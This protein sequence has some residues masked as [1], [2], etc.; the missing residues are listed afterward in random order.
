MKKLILFCLV[1]LIFGSV[2]AHAKSLQARFAYSTFFAPGSGPYAETYLYVGGHSVQYALNPNNKFQASIEVSLIFSQGSAVK[3]FDKYNLLSP[4]LADTLSNIFNFV[5]QQRI[6]LPNGTYSMEMVIR[7]K[8]NANGKPY[9]ITQEVT[10]SYFPNV[11]AI[12]DIEILSSFKPSNEEKKI[13]KNGYELV[14]LVDN[15]FAQEDNNLKFY[16]EIY[17]TSAVLSNEGYLLSYHIE[18]YEQKRI[19]NDFSQQM[20][21]PVKP[22]SIVLADMNITELPSGNYN[23]VIEVRNKTNELLAMREI[24]FQRSKAAVVTE[25]GNVDIRTLDV[26]N[27][28]A[29]TYTSKDTLA[30]Y[31]RCLWPISSPT[32]NIWAMNQLEQSDVKLMQQF[33]YDFWN[34]RNAENPLAAWMTYKAEVDKVNE[35][36]SN[37]N[38]KGYMTERGRVYLQYGPPNQLSK[39]YNEPATYP[40]EVWQY[41]KV[42]NQSNRKFVFYANELASNDMVLLHSDAAGEPKEPQWQ[43]ILQR[44][45]TTNGDFDKTKVNDSYGNHMNNIFNNP[46]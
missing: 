45:T 5:D 4:E 34:R 31:I 37:F 15:F 38:K 17:N 29:A 2:D 7:D 14:P 44:R 19:M 9:S 27:T 22:I 12:S 25:A 1:S 11:I 46:R 20:R 42:K 18:T 23:L 28:F 21:Q 41:Y 40:Y 24:F 35:E 13:V 30:E 26:S 36:Y 43:L 3:Y 32:D 6:S 39:N 10:L 33:F 8:N 16:S